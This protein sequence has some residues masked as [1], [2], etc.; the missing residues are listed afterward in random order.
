M[1]IARTASE[2]EN[3]LA[4][5]K[6]NN[7]HIG[8]VPTMGALHQGHASLVQHAKQQNDYVV[9]SIFV[10]PTQFNN[11]SDLENYPRTENADFAILKKLDVDLVFVPT[12]DEI[13][14]SSFVLPHINLGKL[15]E[16]MEGKYRP[17]HFKGVVQVVY[18]LFEIVKPTRAYFG[19]KDLQQVAV[20][21]FMTNYFNLP[22]EIVPVDTLRE[23]DGLAMSSRNMRLTETQR[24]EAPKIYTILKYIKENSDKYTPNEAR[25]YIQQEFEKTNF[26]LEYVE[27]VDV[28]TLNPLEE[29]WV[30]GSVICVVAYAGEVR[31]I[32]NLMVI[33]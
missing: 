30:N 25:L 27:I 24:I 16:V 32:D 12:V 22:I 19:L 21:R 2:V 7:Q 15:D 6:K 13:Y 11:A 23:K 5:V 26:K 29:T 8:F 14:T 4:L 1:H 17:G 33:E 28:K 10:N 31:L 20:I 3:I 18:R 9:V